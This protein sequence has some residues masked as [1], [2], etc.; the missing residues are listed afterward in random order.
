MEQILD[1]PSVSERALQ[2]GGFWIRFVAALIDGVLL[3]V[4]NGIIG[5]ILGLGFFVNPTGIDPTTLAYYCLTLAIQFGYHAGM[6]ASANQAT[7]GK[8]ALRLKVGKVNGERLSVGIAIGRYSIKTFL[9]IFLIVSYMVPT[10]GPW[11]TFLIIVISCFG[12]L[13]A[14]W[15]KKKQAL[16]D[17]IAGTYVFKD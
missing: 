1:M 8:L 12:Y 17:K 11:I 5:Q 4:V 14:A 6:E 7:L 13:M 15:D 3:A 10:G 16:H 9:G 2:Y